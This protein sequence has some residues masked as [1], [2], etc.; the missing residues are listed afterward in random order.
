MSLKDYK[1]TPD[2]FKSN[3]FGEGV[4]KVKI[5]KVEAGS[6]QGG[7]DYF[8]F[9]FVGT[10]GQAESWG[11]MWLTPKSYEYTARNIRAIAVHNCESDERKDEM[12]KYFDEKVRGGN[13]LLTIARALV[14]RGAECWI[15]RT[16]QDEPYDYREDGTPKYGYNVNFRAYD[17]TKS[18][19]EVESISTSTAEPATSSKAEKPVAKA[20]EAAPIDL[21]DDEMAIIPF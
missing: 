17:P 19:E 14:E 20:V 13:D 16:K 5:T 15:E 9:Y 1:F 6:T 4:Y 8:Q 7:S 12:R 18:Q 3:F 2:S 11:R 10:E 21:S